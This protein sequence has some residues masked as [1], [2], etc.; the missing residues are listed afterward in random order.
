MR[1]EDGK[2]WF[3]IDELTRMMEATQLKSLERNRRG[4]GPTEPSD[5][6]AWTKSSL[7]DRAMHNPFPIFEKEERHNDA[8]DLDAPSLEGHDHLFKLPPSFFDPFEAAWKAEEALE[9]E[10]RNNT[11]ANLLGGY[12]FFFASVH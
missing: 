6:I 12:D 9:N 7:E 10:M 5:W 3:Y 2:R 1:R 4:D 8:P 11:A